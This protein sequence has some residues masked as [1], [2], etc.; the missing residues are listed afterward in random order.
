MAK[1]AVTSDVFFN[2]ELA[3]SRGGSFLYKSCVKAIIER[4][5]T[6]GPLGDV[7]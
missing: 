6:V 7:T 5:I 1:E 3:R 2:W 4:A